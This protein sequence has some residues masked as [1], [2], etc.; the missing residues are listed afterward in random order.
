MKKENKSKQNRLI[1]R[2]ILFILIISFLPAAYILIAAIIS[3][4]TGVGFFGD[5]YGINAFIFVII[6]CGYRGIESLILPICL[7]VQIICLFICILCRINPFKESCLKFNPFFI[8]LIISFFPYADMLVMLVTYAYDGG[9]EAFKQTIKEYSDENFFLVLCFVV[10]IIY[11]LIYCYYKIKVEKNHIFVRSWKMLKIALGI[12][13][14]LCA[15]AGIVFVVIQNH[16]R[17]VTKENI[18]NLET[19]TSLQAEAGYRYYE[20]EHECTIYVDYDKNKVTFFVDEEKYYKFNLVP[21]IEIAGEKI[22]YNFYVQSINSKSFI[23]SDGNDQIITFTLSGC[24]YSTYAVI[25]V[26]PDGKK[27]CCGDMRAVGYPEGIFTGI[28]DK[29]YSNEDWE[30]WISEEQEIQGEK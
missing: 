14:G 27:L 21:L 4:F 13:A 12:T 16:N 1:G 30:N 2:I 22:E 28:P 10:Q 20:G 8:P 17:A 23:Y 5:F 18:R 3:M 15:A 9:L 7:L 29:L 19:E 26:K 6:I 11:L 25:V 24:E